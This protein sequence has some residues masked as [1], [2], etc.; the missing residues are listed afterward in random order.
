MT[1]LLPMNEGDTIT[2]QSGHKQR[3]VIKH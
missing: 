2:A 3:K 1:V